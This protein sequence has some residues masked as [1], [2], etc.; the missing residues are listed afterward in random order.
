M[1]LQ[2]RFCSNP[3]WYNK[4][5]PP[6][7]SPFSS[8]TLYSWPST[9]SA[10]PV[11]IPKRAIIHI[12]K[13]APAPPRDIAT[14]TPAKLPVPTRADKLVHKAWNELIPSLVE[15]LLPFSRLNIWP[16]CLSC[17]PPS[18]T[19]NQIPHASSIMISTW[20]SPQRILLTNETNS[21]ITHFPSLLF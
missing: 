13:I 7:N 11:A 8:R 9:L 3:A 14:A 4:P 12:Q 15:V 10:K 5:G 19:V 17:T 6:R 21:F 18:L 2:A 20:P 16:K 1:R